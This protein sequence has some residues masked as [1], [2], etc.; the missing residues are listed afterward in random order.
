VS[1]F[2]VFWA[3]FAVNATEVKLSM[4]LASWHQPLRQS[5]YCIIIT[6]SEEVIPLLKYRL[7]YLIFN[8]QFAVWF[9]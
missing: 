9:D 2:V 1:S 3:V 4:F 8:F 5:W 6:F 7:S